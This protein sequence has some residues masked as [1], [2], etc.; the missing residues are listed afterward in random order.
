MTGAP[1]FI[2]RSITLQIFCAYAPRERAA[3]DGEVLREDEDLAAVDGA[4]AGDHAV[5]E[6]LLLLHA[7]VGAAVGDEAVELDEGARVEQQVDALARG[8][9]AGL[10]LLVDA[11]LA[12]GGEGALV[13]LVQL[14]QRIFGCRCRA[15]WCARH[16]R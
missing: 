8:E 14:A 10:V 2:A 7:E 6:D 11:L 12:A 15:P 13:E 4:V 16:S 3:E 1:T 5:A 9:L